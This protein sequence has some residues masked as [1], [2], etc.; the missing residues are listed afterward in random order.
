VEIIKKYQELINN[1]LENIKFPSVPI[2]LYEPIKYILAIGGKRIRPLL[3]L[4]SNN[5]FDGETITAL[6]PAISLEIFHNFTL[7]HDDIMDKADMR[8]NK[9]TVHKKWNENIA[10]L[11]GDAMQIIANQYMAE[12]PTNKLSE[13]LKIF[14][15]TALEVCEGQQYDMNFETHLEVTVA[16]YLEMIRLKTSVLI[17]AA[18][19]LGAVLANAS[20]KDAEFIYEYG[21]N[22]GL[23]FQLQDDLL[24]SFGDVNVF[25]KKIGGDILANKKTFLLINALNHDDN[26]F[27]N[28]LI[29]LLNNKNI[30]SEDKIA[31]VFNIY[32][33]LNIKQITEQK[34]D[35]YFK[36]ANQYIEKIE[37]N[38]SKKQD[39]LL[40]VNE[41][42]NR[43]F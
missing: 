27:K 29:N 33:K 39:L 38:I 12:A 43:K 14:N 18:L 7:L 32:N 2:N 3:V 22:I 34:I 20:S 16:E 28:E 31:K 26:Q 36:N 41:L 6:K 23:A 11:S 42:Y 8:R 24:D 40:F 9:P 25:G 21:L 10:I 35:Y 30:E 15:Q 4:L 19:K 37:T 13:C 17:A 5:L 1:E